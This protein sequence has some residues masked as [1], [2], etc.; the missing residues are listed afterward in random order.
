[1]NE[2]QQFVGMVQL[3]KNRELLF[4]SEL[5]LQIFVRDFMFEPPFKIA[6]NENLESVFKKLDDSEMECLPVLDQN[7]FVGFIFKSELLEGY[8]HKLIRQSRELS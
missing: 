8:R 5:Y 6:V 4:N 7:T 3:D 2:K 1:L